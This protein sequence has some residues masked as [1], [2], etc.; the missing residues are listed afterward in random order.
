MDLV[1]VSPEY[2]SRMQKTYGQ[3]AGQMFNLARY[4]ENTGI[5]PPRGVVVI[6]KA[7][8]PI[9]KFADKRTGIKVDISFE[10]D[11]GLRAN[12]TF[13]DW[14]A[15]F[16]AMPVIV[17][18]IKQLLAM[19]GLNEV[20]SGGIGGFTVICL[21]V[22][23]MQ[24][25]PELQSGAMDP[26]LHYGDLLLNFLDLYGNRFDIR[27]TGIVMDPPGYYDKRRTPHQGQTAERLTIIDPN[28]RDNDISG[29]SKRIDDVLDCFRSAH[30]KIQ[31]RL[32]LLHEG[33]DVEESILGCVWGGNYASFIRQREKLSMLHR[34]YAVSPPPPPPA[35]LPKK[36]KLSK[37]AKSHANGQGATHPL[38]AKPNGYA[39]F[40]Q[41]PAAYRPY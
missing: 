7:R 31:R 3:G 19:R 18:L 13:Q 40:P 35:P 24:L 41:H 20:F 22:S 23:M 21:V 5:A 33:E 11:S 12:R 6:T 2:L 39:G 34:G 17:V 16:P 15:Q 9:I 28:R 37:K 25:M 8:V 29:G 38:P 30:A 27:R 10:N 26:Q 4:F 1:A 36:Q 14:K 32:A